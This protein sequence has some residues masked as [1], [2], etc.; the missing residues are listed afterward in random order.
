MCCMA[1]A[2]SENRAA[3]QSDEAVFLNRVPL[4]TEQRRAVLARDYN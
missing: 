4:T 3:F 1:L 2:R